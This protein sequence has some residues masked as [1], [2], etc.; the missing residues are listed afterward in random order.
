MVSKTA[1]NGKEPRRGE[2]LIT[3]CRRSAARGY[4]AIQKIQNLT[5][6]LMSG[7]Q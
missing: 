6:F 5:G 2:I 3:A 1:V 4:G 7:L